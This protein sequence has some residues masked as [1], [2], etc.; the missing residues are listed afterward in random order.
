MNL[1]P[2]RIIIGRCS[3]SLNNDCL[4]ISFNALSKGFKGCV[5]LT[6]RRACGFL[7]KAWVINMSIGGQSFS[8]G[9]IDQ[10]SLIRTNLTHAYWQDRRSKRPRIGYLDLTPLEDVRDTMT[11]HL[12][13]YGKP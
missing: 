11:W 4:H 2:P 3:L 6:R 9:L 1:S 12:Q 10:V 7:K 5:F 8:S 13:V